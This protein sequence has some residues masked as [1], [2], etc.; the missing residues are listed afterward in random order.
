M[1]SFCQNKIITTGEGGAVVTDSDDVA[2]SLRLRRSHGRAS[3]AYFDSAATGEYVTLGYN[4]RM[5]DI[6]AGIGVAQLDRIE[7][8]IARRRHVATDLSDRLAA[9]DHVHPPSEVPDGR[10]V[11]QL[12]TVTFDDAVDRD[13]VIESLN[14]RDIASKVYFDPVHL[15]RYY[16]EEHGFEPGDLPR[17]EQLS[18]RVL[19]LRCIRI[20][21]SNGA[22]GSSMHSKRLS[23]RTW[24]SDGRMGRTE[25]FPAV[26]RSPRWVPLCGSVVG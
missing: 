6:C 3:G 20:S 13:G 2:Q 16:R 7:D 22:A 25:S 12:Y 5:A 17:T 11:Y 8:I 26:S 24:G 9:V 19:S 18:E 14:A 10:H 15:S 23:P 4:H 21:T 1:L